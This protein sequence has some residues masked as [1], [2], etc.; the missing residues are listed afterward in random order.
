MLQAIFGLDA[1]A[2]EETY[3]DIVQNA[4]YRFVEIDFEVP[5]EKKEEFYQKYSRIHFSKF[6]KE[7]LFK[8][9]TDDLMYIERNLW[10]P[11]G[12]YFGLVGINVAL[13]GG[14]TYTAWKYGPR[15]VKILRIKKLTKMNIMKYGFINRNARVRCCFGILWRLSY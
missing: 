12:F 4:A 6:A 5:E 11:Y 3:W 13:F 15:S 10:M 8:Y 1:P 7:T 14:L 9:P 2:Q